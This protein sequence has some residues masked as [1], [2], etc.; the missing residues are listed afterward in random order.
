[1]HKITKKTTRSTKIMAKSLEKNYDGVFEHISKQEFKKTT[2]YL[3]VSYQ[4]HE[5]KVLIRSKW[6]K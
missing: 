3:T 6:K 5:K 1:M 2:T 4:P